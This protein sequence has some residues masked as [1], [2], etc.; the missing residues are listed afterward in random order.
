M[1]LIKRN[2]FIF[3]TLLCIN[4]VY[5]TLPDINSHD[6]KK[7][8]MELLHSHVNYKKIDNQLIVRT[9]DNFIEELDPS[10]T[11]FLKEDIQRWLS[12]SDEDIKKIISDYYKGNFSTFESIHLVMSKAI[13]RRNKFETL[14]E[15]D[16]IPKSSNNEELSNLEWANSENELYDRLLKI[17]SLQVQAVEKIDDETAEKF[18]QRVKKKRI[19]REKEL[20]TSSQEEKSKL[21]YTYFLKAF[22]G[23][24]DAYSTYFTP[25][26]ATQFMM[27]VQQRLFGIG[28]QLRDSLNG[29]SIVRILDG[30]P[31]KKTNKLKINDKIIAVN[32]EPVVGMDIEK[33]VELIRGKKNTPVLLTILREHGDSKDKITEKLDVEIIRGEVVLEE[34]RLETKVE[35]FADGVIANLKL[36]SFYQDPKSSSASDIK[37]A[38]EEIQSKNNLKGVILD[39]RN[40]SG[41]LLSQAKEVAGLFITKGIIV[42]IKDSSGHIQHLRDLD[43]KMAWDGPLVILV[44]KASAS[45]AEIVTQSLQDYGRALVVGDENTFGKGTFQVFTLDSSHDGKVNLKGEYKVTKGKYYT[46]SGKSPQLVGVKSDIVVPGIFSGIEIGEK[47]SKYPLQNDHIE[48]NFEDDLSDIPVLHRN[49]IGRLYKHN[50]QPRLDS[51]VKHL[52]TLRKNSTSRLTLNKSYQNFIKSVEEKKF[53]SE[54]FDI[55]SQAD[56]QLAETYNIMKDLIFLMQLNEQI[57]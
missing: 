18:F 51:Y 42:S 1:R 5:A 34:T 6:V 33:A 13:E 24:L 50:L 25:S 8:T 46:V 55:F 21:I 23:A 22:S 36:F 2:L 40:N 37:K 26:E 17:R 19:N 38:L 32:K 20:L 10:K 39:L 45:A 31:A 56:L 49:E 11:Y 30:G 29:F 47:F 9:L 54:S 44:N 52:D 57:M 16:N 27:Q 41:G 43:G 28:A 4:F 3:L 7:K 53:E 14:I 35:P 15:K 48:A 12:P